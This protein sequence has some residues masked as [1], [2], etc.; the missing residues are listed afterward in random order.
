MA[1][2]DAGRWVERYT[3]IRAQGCNPLNQSEVALNTSKARKVLVVLIVSNAFFLVPTTCLVVAVAANP[4]NP[5]QIAFVEGITVVNQTDESIW[6]TPLGAWDR[7]DRRAPMPVFESQYPAK[8]SSRAGGIFIEAGLERT[9]FVNWDDI[10]LSGFAIEREFGE[11]RV[12]ALREGPSQ[13]CHSASKTRVAVSS[14]AELPIS[15]R[16]VNHVIRLA[17]RPQKAGAYVILIGP[18]VSCAILCGLWKVTAQP[19]VRERSAIRV[20]GRTASR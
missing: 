15:S 10:E 19:G 16:N 2:R 3:L 13:C 6:I 14:L 12:L 7:S 5:M 20:P 11:P 18:F 8:L 4:W 9:V 1:L 17:K